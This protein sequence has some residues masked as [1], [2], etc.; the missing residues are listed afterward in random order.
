MWLPSFVSSREFRVQKSVYRGIAA[1]Y[2]GGIG[3]LVVI[4]VILWLTGKI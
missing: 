3:M 1:V 2:L 4:G